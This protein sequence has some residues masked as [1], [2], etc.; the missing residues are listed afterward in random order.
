M[1]ENEFEQQRSGGGCI[2]LIVLIVIIAF[3]IYAL[4]GFKNPNDEYSQSVGGFIGIGAEYPSKIMKFTGSK[5]MKA[6]YYPHDDP[7]NY[8]YTLEVASNGDRFTE[9]YF[10]NGGYVSLGYITCFEDTIYGNTGDSRFI[11]EAQDN[12]SRTWDIG[13][14]YSIFY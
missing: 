4:N 14:P 6:C 11:C 2:N 9:I 3:I 7:D 12:E 10:P 1:N 8:C 13:L 5:S